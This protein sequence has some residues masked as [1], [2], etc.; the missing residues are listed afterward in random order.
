MSN[1]KLLSGILL[2]AAAGAALGI[3]FAPEKGEE[4]R[5]KI[6]DQSNKLT[7]DVK[8]KA[9]EFGET[10][11]EK[12]HNIKSDAN[13]MIDR[14]KEKADEFGDAVENTARNV[15]NDTRENFA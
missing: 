15:K 14:S 6:K 1:G 8:R 9:N 5:Q 13:A 3:L 7:D 4:T 12:Y 10:V 2:G 11:K